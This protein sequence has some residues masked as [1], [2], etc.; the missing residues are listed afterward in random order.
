MTLGNNTRK[1]Y[2]ELLATHAPRPI[3]SETE[4]EKIQS[5]I[6]ALI[7]KPELLSDDE[8]D[9]LAVLGSLVTAWEDGKFELPDV[10]PPQVVRSLLEDNALRQKDLVGPVFATESLVSEFLSGKRGLSYDQVRKLSQF[11]HV[12]PQVFYPS[13]T[14]QVELRR[15]V[16]ARHVE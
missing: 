9:F 2:A 3:E 12:S 1:T 14:T 11:F 4:A 7:D 8:Q 6:D 15:H 5:L 16:A 13:A 10:P